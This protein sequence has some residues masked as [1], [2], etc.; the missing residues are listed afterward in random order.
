MTLEQYYQI[1]DRGQHF[2]FFHRKKSEFLN[3]FAVRAEN[4]SRDFNFDGYKI[5]TIIIYYQQ[6][7]KY[8]K[9]I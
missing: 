1:S 2:V 7:P 5:Y 8:S 4:L 3:D 6:C 9:Y